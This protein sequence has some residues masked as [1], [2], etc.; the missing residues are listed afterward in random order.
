MDDSERDRM[1]AALRLATP[2]PPRTDEDRVPTSAKVAD[3]GIPTA[4]LAA[5]VGVSERTIRRAVQHGDD[6]VFLQHHAP[7]E[8]KTLE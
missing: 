8:L 6:L 4:A 5:Q 2:Y 3:D 7:E 1:L